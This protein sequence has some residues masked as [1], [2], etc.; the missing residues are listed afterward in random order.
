MRFLLS[1]LLLLPLASFGAGNTNILGAWIEPNGDAINVHIGGDT[2]SFGTN[3]QFYNGFLTNPTTNYPSLTGTQK[4]TLTVGSFGWNNGVNG[5]LTRTLYATKLRRLPYP[6][7]N[8]NWVYDPDGTASNVIVRVALSDYVYA[9][10]TVT[11]STRD[12]WIVNTNSGVDAARVTG[13]SVTNLSALTFGN[14]SEPSINWAHPGQQRWTNAVEYVYLDGGHWSGIDSIDVR[15]IDEHSN[16]QTVSAVH[17]SVRVSGRGPK[18]GLWVAGISTS[19]FTNFDMIRIDFVARPKIGTNV[20]DTKL[21]RWTGPTPLPSSQTNFWDRFNSFTNIAV[22]ALGGDDT[23][24]DGTNGL[25]ENVNAAQYLLTVD[26]AWQRL[27]ATNNLLLGINEAIGTVY[28]RAGITNLSGGTATA[29]NTARS[30]TILKN[31]PGEVARFTNF[32]GNADVSDCWKLEGDTANSGGLLLDVDSNLVPFQSVARLWFDNVDIDSAT[33]QFISVGSSVYMT[34][35]RITRMDAGIV[36]ISV[37]NTSYA[38]L[39][40]VDVSGVNGKVW[41]RTAIGLTRRTA[42]S[43]SFQVVDNRGGATGSPRSAH[44]ILTDSIFLQLG[45]LNVG[46]FGAGAVPTNDV[47]HG[48]YSENVVWEG[49][50]SPSSTAIAWWGTDNVTNVVIRN[51]TVNGIRVFDLYNELTNRFRISTRAYNNVLQVTGFAADLNPQN[52][53][54]ST[55]NVNMLHQ[56]GSSGNVYWFPEG[57]S[58]HGWLDFAGINNILPPVDGL[59]LSTNFMRFQ[60]NRAYLNGTTVGLGDYRLLNNNFIFAMPG[61]GALKTYQ[62]DLG[63][64]IEGK[65]RSA[66]DPPGAYVPGN[67]KKGAMF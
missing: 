18:H 32:T 33:S 49:T 9:G 17:A 25:P 1:I 14:E 38:L 10:E 43:S 63:F 28:V 35:V 57:S 4:C 34:D 51:W 20:F 58:S 67:P 50:N 6:M 2:T 21:D 55:N 45:A 66:I 59:K 5:A 53:P 12:G 60:N 13:L 52:N 26:A 30:W 41:I 39:R 65:T 62:P 11:M 64:D 48:F 7:F 27:A 31:Y 42:G 61:V 47:Y 19:T 54:W 22:V 40:D 46:V 16:T 15:A 29:G 23:N 24:G 44:G 56:V 8:T 37:E 3:V 36:P